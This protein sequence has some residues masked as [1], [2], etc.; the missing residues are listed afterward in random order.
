MTTQVQI[1]GAVEGT[2]SIRTLVSRELD[3]NTTDN[4]LNI[5]NGSDAGGV[6]HTTFADDQNREFTYGS[7]TGTN[8]IVVTL[9]KAPSAYAT[10]QVFTFKAQNN[11][12]GAATINFN[13]L[14]AKT[15]KK[16]VSAD[17]EADDIVAGGIYTVSYDGTNMQLIGFSEG[18]IESVSQGDLNT[19]TGS[20]SLGVDASSSL[21]RST[22]T[23][24]LAFPTI[25]S[26]HVTLAGGQYSFGIRSDS[27]SSNYTTAWVF[28]NN[29]TSLVAGAM[30]FV[31]GAGSVAGLPTAYGDHRYI[32]SSPPF[33]MGDGDVG[34]FFYVLVDSNGDVKGH[35]CADSPPWGYNGKT[36]TMADFKDKY[37]N[38]YSRVKKKLTPEQFLAG[39]RATYE[40]VKITNAIKNAD[41]EDIPHPFGTPESGLTPVLID[42]MDDKIRDLINIQ[43]EGETELV[44][45][46]LKRGMLKVDNT[47]LK[48]G[49]PKG[50]QVSKFKIK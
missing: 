2:Q 27:T 26:P 32:T 19:S 9:N 43:N 1:R 11:N 37:G 33:D 46:I 8:A 50:I 7:A 22:G 39:E 23:R 44:T 15:I 13:S 3:I 18:G 34:G 49:A 17:V 36:S 31:F 21:F 42:P 38:K 16:N 40:Y 29:S 41:M 12:T 35:Y 6:P 28:A 14:G 48:R 30:P 24:V 4:R 25:S 20:F 45:D 47:H 5:H 10:G